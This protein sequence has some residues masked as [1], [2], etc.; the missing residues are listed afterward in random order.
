MIDKR[1]LETILTDQQTRCTDLLLLTK[2]TNEDIQVSGYRIKI[3]AVCE[4]CQELGDATY[5][6]NDVHN[7][8]T[9]APD[10]AS[11]IATT[12]HNIATSALDDTTNI[13]TGD[14]N[15]A[16]SAPNDATN[17]APDH[18]SKNKQIVDDQVR[19]KVKVRMSK[20]LIRACIIEACIVEHSIN[21][22]S[23]L[24][25]KTPDYLRNFIIPDMIAEGILLR[26]K[27]EHTR[28]QTYIS[29][30]QS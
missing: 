8:A 6:A 16:T 13:V 20:E 24:L 18:L 19:P 4:W 1:T 27:P 28:G 7:I 9:T 30:L 14:Y 25:N 2:C 21:E 12:N 29:S 23:A 26:T 22:L 15:I 3:Q 10:D 11:N 17:I 5:I